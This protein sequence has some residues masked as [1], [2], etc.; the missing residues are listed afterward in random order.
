MSI[1]F[2]P[3]DYVKWKGPTADF[4]YTP[5]EYGVVI[6]FDVKS[7]V[8][9]SKFYD[10]GGYIDYNLKHLELISEDEYVMAILSG[11]YQKW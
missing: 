9:T 4:P 6:E 10:V 8:V 2:K 7:G 3:G 1:E 5:N 11:E